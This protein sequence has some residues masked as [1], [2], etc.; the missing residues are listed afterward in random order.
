MSSSDACRECCRRELI[1][2]HSWREELWSKARKSHTY[3]LRHKGFL[4]IG[5]HMLLNAI[6]AAAFSRIVNA[7]SVARVCWVL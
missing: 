7:G 6:S 3:I 5:A 1:A 4:F 2:D